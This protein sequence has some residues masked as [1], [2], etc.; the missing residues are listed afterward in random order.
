M[1]H[2]N[3]YSDRSLEIKIP[4]HPRTLQQGEV[5]SESTVTSN[6]CKVY[7]HFIKKYRENRTADAFF[8]TD[9]SNIKY[10]WS[11]VTVTYL[12]QERCFSSTLVGSEATNNNTELR[13]IAQ[14][15][16]MILRLFRLGWWNFHLHVIICVDSVLSVTCFLGRYSGSNQHSVNTGVAAFHKLTRLGFRFKWV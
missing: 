2:T 8:Y 14:A 7:S 11:G 10:A 4:E 1:L 12:D 13:A 5:H 9:R 6:L 3:N 16:E 15:P